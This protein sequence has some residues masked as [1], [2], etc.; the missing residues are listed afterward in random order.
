MATRVKK[1][2]FA[3]IN[4]LL[5]YGMFS[6]LQVLQHRHGLTLCRQVSFQIGHSD[7]P[8]KGSQS[9]TTDFHH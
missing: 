9:M 6:V 5:Q 3:K 8:W 7:V 4:P 1:E 2:D